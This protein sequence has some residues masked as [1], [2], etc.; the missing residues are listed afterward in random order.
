MS[1]ALVFLPSLGANRFPSP[2]PPSLNHKKQRIRS[3][4]S[5]FFILFCVFYDSKKGVRGRRKITVFLSVLE[6]F[7]GRRGTASEFVRRAANSFAFGRFKK[8]VA[9]MVRNG[10]GTTSGTDSET[11]KLTRPPRY[12]GGRV[13][14][15]RYVIGSGLCFGGV[16]NSSRNDAGNDSGNDPGTHPG[17][18]FPVGYLA[19]FFARKIRIFLPGNAIFFQKKNLKKNL[20]K[21]LWKNLLK[22]VSLARAYWYRRAQAKKTLKKTFLKTFFFRFFGRF[23]WGFLVLL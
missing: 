14:A 11:K 19:I 10:A 21:N 4:N 17:M 6:P 2:G 5:E 7:P 1:A 23:F 9:M 13:N 8:A 12:R 16:P 20:R 15:I 3:R 22:R 18:D